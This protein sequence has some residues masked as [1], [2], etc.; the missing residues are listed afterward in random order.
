MEKILVV[1]LAKDVDLEMPTKIEGT[2]VLVEG[3]HTGLWMKR[4]K[5]KFEEV[6]STC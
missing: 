3:K 1:F 2:P 6:Q 4:H 5:T